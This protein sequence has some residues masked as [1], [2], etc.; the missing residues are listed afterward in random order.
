MTKKRKIILIAVVVLAVLLIVPIFFLRY[1]GN[2]G[3]AAPGFCQ[4][5]HNQFSRPVGPSVISQPYRGP[6]PSHSGIDYAGPIGSRVHAV[7]Q[8]RVVLVRHLHTS[9]GNYIKINHACHYSTLYA[10]LLR[11][12]VQVGQSVRQGQVIGRRGS[13]GNSTG[14]HTHFEVAHN[15]STTNPEPWINNPGP[16]KLSAVDPTESTGRDDGSKLT[17][18]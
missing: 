1:G 16:G 3:G 8:G 6:Y 4:G 10:H 13:T 17:P 12:R 15:G 18:N 7:S 14:P 11:T 2:E 9:Y 5:P